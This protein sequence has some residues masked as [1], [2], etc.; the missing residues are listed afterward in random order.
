MIYDSKKSK[1]INVD[2]RRCPYCNSLNIKEYLYG[3][4]TNDYDREKYVLGG[5]EISLD[6]PRY[7]C[8]DCGKDIYIKHDIEIPG[9]RIPN[10]SINNGNDEYI[11][12]NYNDKNNCYNLKL[13][14]SRV[15]HAGIEDYIS[16][17]YLKKIDYDSIYKIDD[18]QHLEND[19]FDKYYNKLIQITDN[20]I[21]EFDNNKL[22]SNNEIREWSLIINTK[23]NQLSFSEE[24][25]PSN[26]KEFKDVIIDL[27]NL[28]KIEF[29]KRNKQIND[30]FN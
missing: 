2:E 16:S 28:F 12:I 8:S 3:E 4:P 26:I 14:K 20:W 11:L 30:M 1:T 13:S 9:I 5:C 10:T 25:V 24:K 22:V 18:V 19:D 6:N 15:N 17:I 21:K 7:K 27:E 29:E 23:D